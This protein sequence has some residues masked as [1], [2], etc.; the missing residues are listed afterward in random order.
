MAGEKE[1]MDSYWSLSNKE[2]GFY[3]L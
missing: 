3:K 1:E 2:M